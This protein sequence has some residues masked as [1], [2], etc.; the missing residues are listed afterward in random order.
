MTCTH[1]FNFLNCFH[2]RNFHSCCNKQ[3]HLRWHELFVFHKLFVCCVCVK[4][5]IL[6]RLDRIPTAGRGFIL[7]NEITDLEH[8]VIYRPTYRYS[9]PKKK[10]NSQPLLAYLEAVAMVTEGLK[11]RRGREGKRKG[12]REDPMQICQ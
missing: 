2:W 4:P 7:I 9:D 8:G 12:G 5:F 10:K 3:Q 11:E 1:C 6:Q